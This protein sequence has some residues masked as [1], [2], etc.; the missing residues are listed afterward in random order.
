MAVDEHV[1]DRA[2]HSGFSNFE[3]AIQH[4]AAASVP[5]IEAL[6][7][8]NGKDFRASTLRILTPTEALAAAR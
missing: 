3:D 5:A 4:F 7:A 8:R 2:L 6:I 1:V